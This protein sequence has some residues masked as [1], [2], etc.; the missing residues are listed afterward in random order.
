[1]SATLASVFYDSYSF[2]GAVVLVL[3]DSAEVM[4]YVF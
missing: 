4:F 2:I 1:M 3:I